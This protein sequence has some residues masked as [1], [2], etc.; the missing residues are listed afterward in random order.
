MDAV[1]LDEKN[2]GVAQ[3]ISRLHAIFTTSPSTELL[4]AAVSAAE[5]EIT[6]IKHLHSSP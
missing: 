2:G 6:E 5:R 4:H 1:G 3:N